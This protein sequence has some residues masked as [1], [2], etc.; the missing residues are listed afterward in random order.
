MSSKSNLINYGL[1]MWDENLLLIPLDLFERVP[2]GAV[3]T[4]IMGNVVV[5]GKDYI[6]TDTRGGLM[7]FG[8]KPEQYAEA[9]KWFAYL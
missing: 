5:K 3:L 7:A 4:S 9:E 2:N 1:R 6:D 8:V